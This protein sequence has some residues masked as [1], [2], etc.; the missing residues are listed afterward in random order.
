VGSFVTRTQWNVLLSEEIKVG[1][2]FV[3]LKKRSKW[4]IMQ[5]RSSFYVLA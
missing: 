4:N 5:K 3:A 1:D 2:Y